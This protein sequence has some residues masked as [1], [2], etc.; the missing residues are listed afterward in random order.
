[1]AR[2]KTLTPAGE[3]YQNLCIGCDAFHY[4][5]LGPVLE[6]ASARR[7]AARGEQAPEKIV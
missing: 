2:S 1:M 5:V 6:Q 7:R 4:A 3:I